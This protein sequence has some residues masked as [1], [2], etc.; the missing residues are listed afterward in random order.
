LSKLK[1]EQTTISV[2]GMAEEIVRKGDVPV[3]GGHRDIFLGG[4][5]IALD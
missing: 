1:E 3:A 4:G 5:F 2:M